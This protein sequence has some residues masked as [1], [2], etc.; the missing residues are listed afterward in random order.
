MQWDEEGTTLVF[1]SHH[2]LEYFDWDGTDREFVKM[3]ATPKRNIKADGIALI[4][5]Q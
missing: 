5:M 2:T 3:V 1:C 4:E